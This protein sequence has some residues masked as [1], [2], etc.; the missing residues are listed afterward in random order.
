MD[1]T[2]VTVIAGVLCGIATSGSEA[3]L[4]TLGGLLAR[5]P[6]VATPEGVRAALNQGKLPSSEPDALAAALAGGA[7]SDPDFREE[8]LAWLKEAQRS[9]TSQTVSN[10]FSGV[11]SGLVIQAHTVTAE[12]RR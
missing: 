8:L 9:G 1:P 3:L 12:L 4:R 2:S 7:F 10:T 11:A 5:K 6:K